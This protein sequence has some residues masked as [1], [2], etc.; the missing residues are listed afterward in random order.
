MRGWMLT[1]ALG[2]SLTLPAV[3][4]RAGFSPEEL[5]GHEVTEIQATVTTVIPS[6]K[7]LEIEDPQGHTEV[8]TVGSDLTPLALQPGDRVKLSILDGL[9][10][11]L[12]PSQEQELS[13]SREDII[14]PMDMGQMTKGMRVALASGTARV[15]RIDR[16]DHSISLMGPLGG[17]HNLDV[18]NAQGDDDF[19]DLKTGDLVDFRL[20]QPMALSVRKLPASSLTKAPTGAAPTSVRTVRPS[21]SL[22]AEL[23]ES[24]EFAHLDG[25]VTQ[26]MDD[27]QAFVVRGP[28]G[29][30]ITLSAGLDLGRTGLRSGDQVGVDFLE[31]LVVDLLPASAKQLT[32]ARETVILASAFGPVPKGTRVTMAT[33]TAE[34]V[35]IARKDHTISLLGPD[36]H[37]HNLDVRRALEQEALTSLQVGDLVDFRLIQ[38]IAYAI[39]RQATGRS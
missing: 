37:V 3:G 1:A 5:A 2:A 16:Q 31:G 29:H 14:L 12:E 20:I 30:S 8:L 39:Q 27:G 15:I 32:V 25:T 33:G 34:V 9:V 13:F 17:I 26:V 7:V 6:E 10:V 21:A 11:D 18:L 24:F 38:P 28:E 35:R 23:L 19:A 4:A 36:G 22:K